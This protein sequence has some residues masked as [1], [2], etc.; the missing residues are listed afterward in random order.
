MARVCAY[1]SVSGDVAG[2]RPSA[3]RVQFHAVGSQ[4]DD[5]AQKHDTCVP[6]CCV[7]SL[8]VLHRQ[9]V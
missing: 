3:A 9:V 7:V 1:V 6:V 5:E 8:C 2:P 4:G